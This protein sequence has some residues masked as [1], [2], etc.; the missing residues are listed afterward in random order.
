VKH[1]P[2]RPGRAHVQLVL[3]IVVVVSH[4]ELPGS[5]CRQSAKP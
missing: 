2:E 4:F 1:T 5:G 3:L